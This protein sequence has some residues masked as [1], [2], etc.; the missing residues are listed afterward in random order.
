MATV[1]SLTEE[2]IRELLAGWED[3]ALSQDDINA[4]VLQLQTNQATQ[5]AEMDELNNT[6]LPQLR[7][8]LAD[9]QTKM[10]ELNDVT[11]PQLQLDLEQA[12]AQIENLNTV[13]IPALR[14]DVDSTIQN[15]IDRPK[16][17]V[18]SEPP[19]NPDEE[20]RYLVVGD[21]W[22]DSDDNNRQ[23]IWNGVEWSTFNVDIPDFS[24]TV[25]KFLSSSHLIY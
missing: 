24:I 12:N 10:G 8:E 18:Q 15:A 1:V 7:L 22:H 2:K 11:L 4:I 20:E 19:T 25:R 23:R 13:D 16:V 14:Q 21:V 6:T 9:N 5:Q 3:V 17:Y